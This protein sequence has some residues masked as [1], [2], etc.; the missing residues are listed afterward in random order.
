MRLL[1]TYCRTCFS[2]CWLFDT[3]WILKPLFLI[4]GR[5]D[6]S[7]HQKS[8]VKVII[9]LRNLCKISLSVLRECSHWI[10]L[11][12]VVSPTLLYDFDSLD[13]RHTLVRYF[14]TVFISFLLPNDFKIMAQL[15]IVLWN[16]SLA[17]ARKRF[18]SD[19]I[20]HVVRGVC[21]W[22][23][24]AWDIQNRA[25]PGLVS[26]PIELLLFF[27]VLI[28]NPS[29]V[30]IK[31][32]KISCKAAALKIVAVSFR[33]LHFLYRFH[34]VGASEEFMNILISHILLHSEFIKRSKFSHIVP[35][36]PKVLLRGQ[37]VLFIFTSQ[38]VVDLLECV[39]RAF[40]IF[41]RKLNKSICIICLDIVQYALFLKFFRDRLVF[42]RFM[43][44][45]NNIGIG[46]FKRGSIRV[47][48]KHWKLRRHGL[49]QCRHCV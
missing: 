2:V 30:L 43:G 18:L 47:W 45:L 36:F 37:S 33:R 10:F 15:R 44:V 16:F 1:L 27:S 28:K 20:D 35:G 3:H 22:S 49:C 6:V 29:R 46:S 34:H 7:L 40:F 9:L 23:E 19:V 14:W 42:D 4:L 13:W 32:I 17:G 21:H 25:D 8:L 26:F 24:T 41:R 39:R 5:S 12:F 31:S 38:S 48:V 11:I